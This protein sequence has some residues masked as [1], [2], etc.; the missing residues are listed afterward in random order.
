MGNTGTPC[1]IFLIMAPFQTI[2]TQTFLDYIQRLESATID[3]LLN[4][5]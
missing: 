1:E 2:I 3:W 4:T 5:L